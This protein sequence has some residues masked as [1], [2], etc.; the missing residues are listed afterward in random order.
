MM[1]SRRI[2]YLQYTNPAAYP[3]LE[4]S[5]QIIAEQGWQVLFL[6]AGAVG[7]D[8]L[9]FPFHPAI[10]VRQ[11]PFPEPGWRQKLSF[12]AYLVWV[13]GH[14]LRWR[15]AWIYASD[16]FACPV[17]WFLTFWPG[18]R[19]IYHEHDAPASSGA[20]VFIR[21]L[22]WTRAR[23]AKRADLCVIP[24]QQRAEQFARE[25][26]PPR[27]PAVVWNCPRKSEA[28]ACLTEPDGG[29]MWVLYNGSIV[30]SRL[31]RTLVA[32]LTLL[33]AAVRLRIVGY[34]T[35]GAQGYVDQLLRYAAELG[36][37]D[38]VEHVGAVPQR[39]EL[40]QIAANCHVGLS[41]FPISGSDFNEQTMV[42]PSNKPFGYLASGI[43]LIV[44]QLN[45]WQ[46]V[47]VDAG[48]GR[49]CNPD[50]AQSIAHVLE[51]YWTHPVER[52]DM[53]VAGRQRILADWNYETQ[54]EPVLHMMHG[55]AP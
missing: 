39:Q 41:I 55:T 25:L 27:S 16:L 37:S 22:K 46:D 3:P 9:R 44:S 54:F 45:D 35:V 15:P 17:A 1:S 18:L 31:P 5:S 52:R 20:T 12:I 43:P 42:G 29:E 40:T 8:K 23:L 50:D 47:F 24:S 21:C 38:R 30:P 10:E 11:M 33:P 26:A 14:V 36:V 49:A 53:G 48:Y 19:V 32:A 4:H 28:E 34:E 13:V 7:A 6:G 2:L 51:W